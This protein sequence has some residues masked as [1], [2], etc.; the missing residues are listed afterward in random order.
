MLLALTGT[1]AQMMLAESLKT[2]ET[3]AVLPFDFLKIVWASA[4]GYLLFAEIPT[5][6]VFVGAGVIFGS[7]FYVAWRERQVTHE[8]KTRP[9][10]LGS[11]STD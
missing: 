11:P 1:A 6:Y 8:T 3:T 10:T 4:L 2:A 7:G 9:A 5:V